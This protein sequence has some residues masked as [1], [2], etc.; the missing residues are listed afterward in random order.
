MGRHWSCF[1]SGVTPNQGMALDKMAKTHKIGDGMDLLMELTG[2]SRSKVGKMDRMSL[3]PYLDDAFEKFSGPY[4]P[5]VNPAPVTLDADVA[6]GFA[7]INS[8]GGI[9]ATDAEEKLR[10]AMMQAG[11]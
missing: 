10:E 11:M 2:C 3:R 6:A 7:K 5:P 9:V 8:E 4:V 1:C